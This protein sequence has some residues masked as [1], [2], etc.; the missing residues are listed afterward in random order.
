M[1]TGWSRIGL[2]VV[3]LGA[4]A[5]LQAAPRIAQT[6]AAICSDTTLLQSPPDPAWVLASYDGDN[7]R[8]PALPP[9]LDG[10]RARR[11]QVTAAMAGVKL[12]A[13]RAQA[14]E[15]CLAGAIAARKGQARARSFQ[16]VETHRI[17]VSEKNR[18]LAAARMAAA[19]DAFNAYGSECTE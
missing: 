11:E 12:Y 4:P 6:F 10:A 17:L 3:L 8:A 19:I 1:H 13:V 16:R 7:C 15:H 14:F 2:A 5:A 18:R 9:L